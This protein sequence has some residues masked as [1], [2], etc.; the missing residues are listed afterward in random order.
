VDVGAIIYVGAALF[1]Y[2]LVSKRLASSPISGPL[3]FVTLGLVGYAAGILT[4]VAM[5][6]SPISA[7]LEFT[8]ALL[9]FTDASKLHLRSWEADMALP[10]RLLAIG[11]PLTIVLGT[12]VAYLV[13]P[14]AGIIGAAII[15]TILAP[16]DA[17]LGFAVVTNP[18]V[19]IRIREALG[20]ESGLND[21]I[22]L[23]I[24]LFLFTLAEAE[25]G[26]SLWRFFI[27]GIGIALLVGLIVGIG[28][29]LAIGFALERSWI[30]R[31]WVRISMVAV[32]F[33]TYIVA[34]HLGGSG[35]IA[36]YV[37]GIGFGR[38]IDRLET[39]SED[40]A[41]LGEDLGTVLTMTSF[42]IFGAYLLAPNLAAFTLATVFYAVI[43]LTA[44]RMIPVA[45]SMID[46]P[47]AP[48]TLTYLGWFGP[49]G[50]A[51]IVFV[52]VLVEEVDTDYSELI[53]GAVIVTVALSVLL[54]GVTAPWGANT[55][56]AWYER[57]SEAVGEDESVG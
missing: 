1:A 37:A 40:F 52:G 3:A 30:E 43:S 16:T 45:L 9:L 49:R 17:A 51:S 44:V 7:V 19:P 35:F 33:G 5:I 27:E 57:Q 21:G 25:A 46:T 29:A 24:L 22:A 48:P 11:M 4:P 28:A 54:H 41:E 14:S 55:Y 8:L 34:D 47:L 39:P 42:L 56:G 13:F 32:A 23:P 2:A 20:V 15:A 26:A 10:T 38:V 6:G 18:R 53:V 36:A 31:Q 50:L 12:G